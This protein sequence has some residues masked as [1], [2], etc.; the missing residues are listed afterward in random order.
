M[1]QKPLTP[2]EQAVIN[3]IAAKER[4]RPES[5]T[6]DTQVDGYTIPSHVKR[7]LGCPTMMMAPR[8]SIGEIAQWVPEGKAVSWNKRVINGALRASRQ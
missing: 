5:L 3:V 2:Q 4:L 1:S 6:P 8:V 7:T